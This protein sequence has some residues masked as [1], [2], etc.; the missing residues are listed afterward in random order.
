MIENPLYSQTCGGGK[1]SPDKDA[2]AYYLGVISK[3]DPERAAFDNWVMQFR[4]NML[5][6]IPVSYRIDDEDDDIY[7]KS[8]AVFP[9]TPVSLEMREA[10]TQALNKYENQLTTLIN[11]IVLLSLTLYSMQKKQEG[12]R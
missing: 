2:L 10:L 3:E 6:T 7:I 4:K 5:F 12:G 1:H 11:N 9:D 8:G